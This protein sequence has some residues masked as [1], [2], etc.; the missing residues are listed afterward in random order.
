MQPRL[1]RHSRQVKRVKILV[2]IDTRGPNA[3]KLSVRERQ[4]GDIDIGNDGNG[5]IN[6]YSRVPLSRAATSVNAVNES[7]VELV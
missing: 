6:I 7:D 4:K 5:R 1:S 3:R 2:A